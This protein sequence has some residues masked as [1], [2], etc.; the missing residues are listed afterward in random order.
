MYVLGGRADGISWHRHAL[1]VKELVLVPFSAPRGGKRNQH[2]V[3]KAHQTP[4]RSFQVIGAWVQ[5]KSEN[6]N[7]ATMACGNRRRSCFCRR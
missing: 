3:P 6:R 5:Y 7:P 4:V 1:P 2:Q